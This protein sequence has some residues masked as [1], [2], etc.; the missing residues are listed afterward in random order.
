M[1]LIIASDNPENEMLE[2]AFDLIK[3]KISEG[4][5]FTNE[6]KD[7]GVLVSISALAPAE[8]PWF[9]E[10]GQMLSVP[11]WQV[12]WGQWLRCQENGNAQAPILDPG[13][14]DEHDDSYG[15]QERLCPI[16]NEVFKPDA[17]GQVYDK[18]ECGAEAEL[19]ARPLQPIISDERLIEPEPMIDI[20]KIPIP[21]D[22]Q[23]TM[24]SQKLASLM[25]P[26]DETQ[27]VDLG[28]DVVEE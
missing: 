7:L 18:N 10:V 26:P 14:Q 12:L 21:A 23:D 4:H 17:R 19:R 5:R 15:L 27:S 6:Q 22:M 3:R 16:C 28:T 11:L 9:H 8:Q 25:F 24:P 13:W 20:T 1:S 2:A